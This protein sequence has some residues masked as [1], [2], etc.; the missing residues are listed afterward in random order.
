M[1]LTIKDK[2]LIENKYRTLLRICSDYKK[3]DKKIISKAFKL[4][5]E[6]HK[7]VKRKSGEPYILHPLS[8]SIICAREIGLGKTSIICSLLHDVVEDSKFTIEDIETLF[9]I[10]IREIVF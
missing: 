8:V 2:K 7:G 5:Y 3:E 4:A 10:F 1:N 6:A 9:E